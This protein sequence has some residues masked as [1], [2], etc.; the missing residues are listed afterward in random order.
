V[1]FAS[2]V[3]PHA[4]PNAEC[5]IDGQAVEKSLLALLRPNAL[6]RG[7]EGERQNLPGTPEI[8]DTILS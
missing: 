4:G 7:K 1:T 5:S 6:A 3:L 2:L 8:S